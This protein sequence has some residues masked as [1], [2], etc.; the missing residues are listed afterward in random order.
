MKNKSEILQTEYSENFDNLR[1]DRMVVSYFKYGP[2]AENYK[3]LQTINAIA[4][5]E[6]R[7]QMYKETGN[8]E[9]LVDSANFCMIEFMYPQHPNAHFTVLDDRKSHIVGMGINEM[10]EFKNGRLDE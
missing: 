6:K 4:S 8:T 7:L 10:E 5:L 1:K 9:F 3:K 2:V